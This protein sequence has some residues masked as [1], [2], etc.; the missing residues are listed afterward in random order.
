MVP[1]FLSELEWVDGEEDGCLSE[2]GVVWVVGLDRVVA[3]D[4][5]AMVDKTEPVIELNKVAQPI[6]ERELNSELAEF[7]EMTRCLLASV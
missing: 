2:E 3:V 5:V 1:G 6:A 4:K 7:L